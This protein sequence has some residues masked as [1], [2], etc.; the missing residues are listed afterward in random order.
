MIN[1]ELEERTKVLELQRDDIR[2]KNQALE[3]AQK[4]IRQKAEALEIASQ[5][6][7]EFLANM[8]HELRTPLNSIL[9]LSE[10]LASNKHGVMTRDEIDFANIIHTSGKDLLDLINDILDLSK[11][12][13]GKMEIELEPMYPYEIMDYVTKT[14]TPLTSSKGIQLQTYLDKN[15]P[16]SIETDPQR[17]MQVVK[18]LMSNAI[19]F[20]EKG[21]VIIRILRLD[22]THISIQV[23]DT[24]IGIPEDKVKIIFEAFQQADGTINRKFGGTGLGLTISRNLVAIL[25]GE[26]KLESKVGKGSVFTFILPHSIR[27]QDEKKDPIPLP[28]DRPEENILP[29][30]DHHHPYHTD[31]VFEGK[32]I[33]IVDD[34]MRNVYVL[35]KILEEKRVRII[36]G[37]NGREGLEKLFENPDVNLVL[38]DIM[39]PEIDGYTAMREIRKDERFAQLPVIALTAKAMKGDREKCIEAGASDYLSKPVQTDKLLTLLKLWLQK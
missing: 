37:R 18:N 34:D 11:V 30:P 15:L 38:M 32:K 7:S 39:M 2:K 23:E 5:Y 10:I 17:V 16:E 13:A 20:T 12:E 21:E 3:Q 26:L 4:E 8:S 6:K 24:G 29:V 14:F 25:G 1:E 9:V 19:K 36:I 28:P 27:V 35:S 22:D 31:A 33:L